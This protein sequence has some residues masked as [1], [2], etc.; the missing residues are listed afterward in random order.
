MHIADAAHACSGPIR[1]PDRIRHVR[2]A[3]IDDDGKTSSNLGF[4][5]QLHEGYFTQWFTSGERVGWGETE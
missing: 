1:I 5:T 2:E 4:L 3:I